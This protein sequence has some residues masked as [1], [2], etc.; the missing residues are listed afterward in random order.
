MTEGPR[1]HCGAAVDGQ[2][3]PRHTGGHQQ[4]TPGGEAAHGLGTDHL[5]WLGDLM[6]ENMVISGGDWKGLM[7]KSPTKMV[8][9]QGFQSDLA[10]LFKVN[11]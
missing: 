10:W 8:M 4:V 5:P 6:G 1:H 9:S 2:P 11:F 7:R 3:H